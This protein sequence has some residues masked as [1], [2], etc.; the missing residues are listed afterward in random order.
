MSAS[1][2]LPHQPPPRSTTSTTTISIDSLTIRRWP[3]HHLPP[4]DWWCPR[5]HASPPLAC[6]LCRVGLPALTPLYCWEWATTL[7]NSK[8]LTRTPNLVGVAYGFAGVGQ[9]CVDGKEKNLDNEDKLKITVV[10][11]NFPFKTQ[12]L[13]IKQTIVFLFF[14]FRHIEP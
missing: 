1:A 2:A 4:P 8:I 10:I 9:E 3:D 12:N 6:H 14:E 5:R 13:H 11:Y 7:S